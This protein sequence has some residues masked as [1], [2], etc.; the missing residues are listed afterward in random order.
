[1]I[2]KLIL[3]GLVV[4]FV[5]AV[6][7]QTPLSEA[8]QF[9]VKTIEGENIWLF[10]LLDNEQK[11]VVIDFFSTGC[12]PC[13]TYAPDYQQ[14]YEAFGSNA[15]NV[16]FMGINWGSDNQE[17]HEFDSVFGLSYPSVSGTQGGG[18]GTYMAYEVLSYPTVIVITPDHQ[19]VEQYIWEPTA[20]HIIDAVVAAGGLYVGT[21]EKIKPEREFSI[22]P[23][24]AGHAARLHVETE[25]GADLSYRICNI[26]GEQI[27]KEKLSLSSGVSSI[28]LPADQLNNGIYFVKISLGAKVSETLRFVVAH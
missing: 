16:F 7:A 25:T 14:A 10:D 5:G 11:I 18:N 24:P 17:V 22:H 15:N 23:N 8:V 3:F 2:R 26:L 12:G 1:M 19:I 4:V 9:H 20:T 21:A 6:S 28:D 13:Q 27:F